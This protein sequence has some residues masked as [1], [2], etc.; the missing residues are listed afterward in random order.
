MV[1]DAK[2]NILA[3]QVGRGAAIKPAELK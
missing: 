2:M 1:G 3:I